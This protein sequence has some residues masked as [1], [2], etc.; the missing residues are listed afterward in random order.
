VSKVTSEPSFWVIVP[1]YNP[2]LETWDKWLLALQNQNCKPTQVVVVDSGSSDGAQELS[3]KAGYKL[4]RIQAQDFN[5]GKTRQWALDHTLQKAQQ[6][7]DKLPEFVV[8]LTQDAILASPDALQMLLSAFQDPAV[9]AA[10]GRQLP[11]ANASWTECLARSFNYPQEARKVALQDKVSLGIR[12]CFMS[13]AFA[14]YRIHSMQQQ[15]GFPATLPLGE[16]TYMAAKFLMFG[17]CVQYQASAAVYHSHHYNA[18]QDFRRMF[19]TGVF[20]QQNPWLLQT[21]GKAEKEGRKLVHLQFSYLLN[22]SQEQ[23]NTQFPG[24]LLGFFQLLISNGAK[25]A[26]YKMGRLNHYLPIRLKKAMSM[27]PNFWQK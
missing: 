8:Y 18:Q 7:G 9:A 10:F 11:K 14:A 21:F 1:T 25:L 6:S 16:D 23:A 22:G 17:Q 19:D 15:G 24:L 13:N 3:L 2:G 12:A 5:H 20:H 27:H 4:L 26:G